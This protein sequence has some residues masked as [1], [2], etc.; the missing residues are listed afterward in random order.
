MN[1]NKGQSCVPDLLPQV[2]DLDSPERHPRGPASTKAPSSAMATALITTCYREAEAIGPFMEAVLA[3]TRWPDE[4]IVVDAGSPDGTVEQ[5]RERVAA[6]APITLIVEPGANRSRG[7]NLGVAAATAEIIALTDV[8]S[9][10]RPDWFER[11]V[12]PLEQDPTVDVVAGYYVAEPTTLWEAAVAAATVPDV[13]E[14]NPETFLPSARSI[15][16]RRSAW[17]KAGGYPEWAS[18]NEDTPFDL[19]LK[20]AGARFVFEPEAVV[21]WRPQASLRRLFVQFYRYARGDAQSRLWFGHYTKAYLVALIS[22]GL[23][24]GGAFHPPV[25]LGLPVLG[26]L[27]WLRHA[28]RAR[29]R[30]RSWVAAARAPFANAIVDAAHVCGYARGLLERRGHGA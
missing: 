12:A 22:L 6:G 4:I 9:Q 10:P 2:R 29:R 17:E 15:G 1:G 11:I 30:T 5:I 7:R 25:L 14:V 23:A 3:Q 16:F 21:E 20:R 27:Y 13:S 18:H 19:A 24:V 28:L 26:V 8:G